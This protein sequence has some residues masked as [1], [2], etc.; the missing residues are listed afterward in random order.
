[1]LLQ[2]GMALQVS[3]FLLMV[4]LRW[5]LCLEMFLRVAGVGIIAVW[6]RRKSTVEGTRQRKMTHDSPLQ[7][8]RAYL[9]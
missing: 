6:W 4:T 3:L 8:S 7:P 5:L 1:M 9:L 2:K